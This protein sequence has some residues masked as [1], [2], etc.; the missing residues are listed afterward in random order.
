M[1]VK[2]AILFMV[3]E[4]VYVHVHLYLNRIEIVIN[5]Y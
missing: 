4:H 2:K 3:D 1:Y 5:N